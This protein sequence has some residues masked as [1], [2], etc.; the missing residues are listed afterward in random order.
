M[1]VLVVEDEPKLAKILRRGLERKGYAVD[2]ALDGQ[3]GLHLGTENDYDAIVLDLMIPVIDGF[4]VCR[5]LRERERWAPVLMLTA[6]DGISDRVTGLD[7]GADDY[8]VKPFSFEELLARLRSLTRRGI[9]ERPTV[10]RVGSLELDPATHRV[11]RAGVPIELRPKE[12]SLLEFF[13][14]HSGEVLSRT[15]VI[16]HVW[17]YDYDGISNVVDVY[18]KNVRKKIDTPPGPSMLRTVRGAGYILEAKR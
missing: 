18:V 16:D 13:M 12:Y 17:N 10:L 5:Q 15:N 3:D 1:R 8:L 7:A 4:E 2:T 11:S 14:R 6:R 9:R